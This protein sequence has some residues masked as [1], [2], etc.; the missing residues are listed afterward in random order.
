M[1]YLPVAK[2]LFSWRKKMKFLMLVLSVALTLTA[3]S[4]FTRAQATEK[5]AATDKQ[6]ATAPA[7]KPS[8]QASA[9]VNKKCPVS[10]DPVDPKGQTFSFKGQKIGF[11]CDDCID[12]FKKD[13]EKYAKNLK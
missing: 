11:C 13:P 5:P 2:V 1:E 9:P 8:T 12:S 10:G 4:V 3:V 7:T 6:A